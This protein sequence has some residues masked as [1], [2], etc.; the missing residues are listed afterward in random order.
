MRD[1]NGDLYNV[2]LNAD[3]TGTVV[4][5][6]TDLYDEGTD[7]LEHIER[8][9]I[10][11]RDGQYLQIEYNALGNLKLSGNNLIDYSPNSQ[12]DG[13]IIRGT[14]TG[15]I[16]EATTEFNPTSSDSW[17]RY[18]GAGGD[19]QI[20]GNNSHDTALYSVVTEESA[21]ILTAAV[22][23]Q[24]SDR[25]VVSND[26]GALYEI[27]LGTDGSGNV[28]DLNTTHFD[29]GTDTLSN[30]ERV[31]V[32]DNG[33]WVAVERDDSGNYLF[34]GS[35]II[36]YQQNDQSGGLVKGTA[37][38]DTLSAINAL[39]KGFILSDD[40][41]TTLYLEGRQGDDDLEGGDGLTISTYHSALSEADTLAFRVVDN[42]S[43][44]VLYDQP[45]QTDL[46]KFTLD[47]NGSGWVDDL[48]TNEYDEGTDTLTNI[49]RVSFH[50]NHDGERNQMFDFEV[51]DTGIELVTIVGSNTTEVGEIMPF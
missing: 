12:G 19:D 36:S 35:N 41:E 45:S 22:D 8:V 48:L 10:G 16:I 13:G 27:T 37:N 33:M 2:T 5:L 9:Q 28:T 26:S 30:I 50:L 18:E 1:D 29:E 34:S 43:A 17:I 32:G 46:Y 47:Q 31:S 4:D 14:D 6:R 42:N 40:P 44:V 15:E 7:T 24:N 21:G 51:S 23:P 20:Q 49:D 3:G 39:S 38:N 11:S 25:V